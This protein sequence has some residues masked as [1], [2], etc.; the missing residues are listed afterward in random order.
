MCDL[1]GPLLSPDKPETP[2][3]M[4]FPFAWVAAQGS[5][6]AKLLSTGSMRRR[7]ACKS[8]SHSPWDLGFLCCDCRNTESIM[9]DLVIKIYITPNT[10][11]SSHLICSVCWGQLMLLKHRECSAGKDQARLHI[12]SWFKVPHCLSTKFPERE[13]KWNWAQS[14]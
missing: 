4:K 8:S 9:R 5:P 14:W 2:V 10:L 11:F 13:T 3:N 12:R 1:P 7:W 6:R